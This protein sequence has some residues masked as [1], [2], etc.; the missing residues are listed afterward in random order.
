MSVF[1]GILYEFLSVNEKL[2]KEQ[3]GKMSKKTVARII[4]AVLLLTVIVALLIF[5]AVTLTRDDDLGITEE[6]LAEGATVSG[7]A[8]SGLAFDDS[9]LTTWTVSEKGAEA[10]VA[11]DGFKEVNALLL[12]ENGFNVTRFSVY[13]DDGEDWQL[14]YRQNEMGINRLATFYTVKAK[15][16]K[17]VIDDYKHGARI[18]DVKVYCLAPR[19][20]QEKLRVT[21]YVTVGSVKDYDPETG[22]SGTISKDVFDVVTDVQFIAFGRFTSDG[23]VDYEEDA[24]ECLGK[25]K[26][27]IDGRDV[28]IRLTVFPPAGDAMADVFRYHMDEA[29]S[30]VVDMVLEQDVDGADFDWEYPWGKEEYALYSEYLVKLSDELHKHGKTLSIAVS[31]WGLDF[32]DEAVKAIDQVQIMAYD[33]FDHNGDNNSYAGSCASTI[34]Y[35]L[36]QGFKAEQLNLGISYY[37]RPSDASGVWVDY[38]NPDYDKD[39]YIMVKDEIYFNSATTVRDKAVYC[40][41]RGLGGIMTFS[42]NE[43]LPFDDPLSLTAQLG[44]ARD[45]FSKEAAR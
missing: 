15:A 11:F 36:K 10:V 4:P 34:D 30:S 14:C 24:E 38:N 42:Q 7:S 12:N 43:D 1:A 2:K 5:Y 8:G 22:M 16:I 6:N 31:P 25:L 23:G 3:G 27:M 33:L 28:K 20:R 9:K 17:L 39:E 41:L 40:I 44:K 32:S 13:Y 29:V 35:M 21:S 45:A 26:E 18:S 37:G 19:E